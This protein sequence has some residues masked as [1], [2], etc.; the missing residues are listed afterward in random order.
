MLY[1]QK[2]ELAAD[3]FLIPK[4][5]YSPSLTKRGIYK[6]NKDFSG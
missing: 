6:K 4:P 2:Y 1:S 3:K 5:R